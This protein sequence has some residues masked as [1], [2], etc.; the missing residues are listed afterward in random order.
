MKK[1]LLCLAFLFALTSSAFSYDDYEEHGKRF[2]TFCESL[3]KV[4]DQI[5]WSGKYNLQDIEFVKNEMLGDETVY[6]RAW[7]DDYYLLIR[8]YTDKSWSESYLANF[9]TSSEELTF[10]NGI[11]VGA[12]F[13]KV[14]NFFGK[15]HIY[16]DYPK[17]F[18][19]QEEES[20]GGGIL[21]FSVDNGI[22]NSISFYIL[23]YNQTSKMNFIF[24]LYANLYLAE[25]TGEKVNVRESAPNGEIKFQVSK[26]KGDRLLVDVNERYYKGWYQ[27][28]GRIV[29]N[30]LKTV[31]YYSISKQFVNV[32]KLTP[33]ER[34]NFISQYKKK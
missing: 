16:G 18:V 10:T 32:R 12:P 19:A 31:P 27:V 8:K 29:N 11:K 30:S 13:S 28:A 15:K 34:K 23:D 4:A 20:D 22:I 9:S 7:Y 1:F 25:V 3:G 6:S 2:I 33:S 26:S 24:D 14:E 21:L 17:Y 5:S